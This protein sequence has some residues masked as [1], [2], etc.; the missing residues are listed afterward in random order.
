MRKLNWFIIICTVLAIVSTAAVAQLGSSEPIVKAQTL[1]S[2][3]KLRPGDEF[4][5]AV[6]AVVA[7]GYHV[8]SAD[9]DALSPA[10]LT[11]SA[12]PGIEFDA[13]VFPKGVRKA[14]PIAPNEKIPVYE[15]EFVVTVNGRV[16]ENAEPGVVTVTTS[17]TTQACKGDQCFPSETVKSTLR[18]S[19]AKPGSPVKAV[20]SNLFERSIGGATG[21]GDGEAGAVVDKLKQMGLMKRLIWLYVVGLGLAFTPCVYPMFPITVGYFSNQVGSNRRRTFV[22]AGAYVFGLALTYSVLGVVAAI[23][24]G[25][26]GAA[27]QSSGVIVAI[28]AILVVLALSMF[29]LYEIQAPSF[30][31]SKAAGRSGILGALLMGL[32]F[33]IVAAPCVGPFVLGTLLYVA[34]VG[35]PLIGFAL[36]FVLALGIGTP[37]FF[38]AAFSARMPVPGMWM[39]AVKKAAG[40]MLLGAAAYFL[41]PIAPT[42]V[43]KFLVPGVI[44]VAGLYF[45]FLDTSLRASRTTAS[46]GRVFGV[47]ALVVAVLLILPKPAPRAL[48]WRSYQPSQ[49][50]RSIRE[51]RPVMIDFTAKWCIACR[52]LEERSFTDQK[53]I[54]AARR[55]DRYRVDCTDRDEPANRRAIERFRVK[56][57]PTVIL[58][59][60]SGKEVRSLRITGFL[61]AD[62]ITKRLVS[63]K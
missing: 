35:S 51:G 4:Q 55:F 54:E 52:E 28:S 46:I 20:N 32:V 23:T 1:L 21:S 57:F 24:G 12:S 5:L 14:F 33:G 29:G 47:V 16:L 22:L 31:Q 39:V 11:V 41:T 15:G 62:E 36:F 6:R 26:F 45:I 7:E 50:E 9:K 61:E 8:G 18:T 34:Y 2:V 38:V 53:L 19:I 25:V 60:S 40:F 37:L 27:M 42:L 3:D 59:D 43:G 63:V 17:L 44:L 30:I 56:G 49:L 13:P 58:L 48:T 10:R